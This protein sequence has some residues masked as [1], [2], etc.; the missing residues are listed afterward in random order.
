M[1]FVG[2]FV[3]IVFARSKATKTGTLHE[4]YKSCAPV[5]LD[6][7]RVV[8]GSGKLNIPSDKRPATKT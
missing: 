4:N 5:S 1:S 7:D 2:H 3:P 8:A 6:V